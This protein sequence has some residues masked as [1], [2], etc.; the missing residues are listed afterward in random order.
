MQINKEDLE[1]FKSIT[2][3]EEYKFVEHTFNNTINQQNDIRVGTAYSTLSNFYLAKI[4]ENS[5]DKIIKSNEKLEKSNDE[6]NKKIN[7]LTLALVFVG[8][9]Q[10]IAAIAQVMTA[11]L[12]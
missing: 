10:A 12:K 11:I 1:I 7:N 8:I 6:N 4:I 5:V 3:Q 2:S 9:I